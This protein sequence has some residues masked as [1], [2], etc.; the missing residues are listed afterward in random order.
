MLY[1][2][3]R[4]KNVNTHFSKSQTSIESEKWFNSLCEV[5]ND[6]ETCK[7]DSVCIDNAISQDSAVHYMGASLANEWTAQY[8]SDPASFTFNKN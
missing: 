5:W 4:N 8:L 2:K 3:L 7:L 1:V 6:S